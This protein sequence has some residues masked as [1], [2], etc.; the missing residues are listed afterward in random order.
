MSMPKSSP[1]KRVNFVMYWHSPA[2]P[3]LCRQ[4]CSGPLRQ[5][6]EQGSVHAPSLHCVTC[7]ALARE[8]LMHP[9]WT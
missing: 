9:P 1:E 8:G 4:G 6:E 5:G 7:D 2:P 3:P